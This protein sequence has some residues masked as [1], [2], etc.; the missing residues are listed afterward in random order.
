[1][2]NIVRKTLIF[3]LMLLV[4]LLVLGCTTQANT[5]SLDGESNVVNLTS[6]TNPIVIGDVSNRI[7]EVTAFWQPLAN[8]L[9]AELDEYGITHG[10][11]R[12][13]PDLNTMSEW[14]ES[15]EVDLYI[16]S[17]YPSSI[18]NSASQGRP[19]LRHWRDFVEEYHSV[20]FTVQEN[21]ITT[22]E[23]LRGEIIAY[24]RPFST[25]GYFLPTVY[26]LQ[27]GFDVI[28]VDEVNSSINSSEIGYVFANDD[29]NV[30]NWVI[31][32]RANVG[33]TNNFE[34]A[35]IP[36][37]T[38]DRLLIIAETDPIPNQIISVSPQVEQD[39][40]EATTTVLM[41]M[42]NNESGKTVLEAIETRRFDNLPGGRD[43]FEAQINEML[44]II[45]GGQ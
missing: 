3:V 33:V 31:A 11:V 18:V 4:P 45:G 35:K 19:I 37:E 13:A 22:L 17:S 20:F 25:S 26:L 9:A 40:I 21:G 10:I 16:D 2:Q 6:G 34:Y 38:R 5:E 27:N 44:E 39:L 43:A 36:E 32:G 24:D 7:D 30:I 42:E 8:Y 15:G 28:E 41:D 14:L 29:I 12:V 23:D 1:M